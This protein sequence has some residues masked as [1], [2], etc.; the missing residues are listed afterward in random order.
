MSQPESIRDI[1]YERMGILLSLAEEA[2]REKDARHAKRYVF[3]ARKLSTRY[4]CRFSK[5]DRAR[6]CK[7][8]GMPRIPGLNTVVRLRKR[9]RTAEYACSCGKAAGFKY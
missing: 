6:F 8:C 7:S 2:L 1:V 5:T 3:L 9:T 4:N